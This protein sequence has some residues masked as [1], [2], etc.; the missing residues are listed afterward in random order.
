MQEELYTRAAFIIKHEGVNPEESVKGIVVPQHEAEA[1]I[2]ALSANLDQVGKLLDEP[3]RKG[4]DNVS[5]VRRLSIY[6]S[7]AKID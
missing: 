4:E 1:R 7:R 5:Y 2:E 3:R 6:F